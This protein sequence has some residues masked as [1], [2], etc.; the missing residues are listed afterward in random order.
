MMNDEGL[1]IQQ[2]KRRQKHQPHNYPKQ[3]AGEP[4]TEQGENCQTEHDEIRRGPNRRE[5]DRA[6]LGVFA[7]ENFRTSGDDCAAQAL[8]GD[9]LN[10]QID[11]VGEA[12]QRQQGGDE[13]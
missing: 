10:R 4:V 11:R 1:Q 9:V 3:R 8:T 7:A 5:R 6:D 13:M 2:P 12:H